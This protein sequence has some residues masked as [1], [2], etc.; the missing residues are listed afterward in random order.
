MQATR[1]FFGLTILVGSLI[2]VLLVAM[3]LAF[4]S[5]AGSRPPSPPQPIGA[6]TRPAADTLHFSLVPERDIFAQRERYRILARYLA[7]QICRP[8]EMV[9][10]ANYQGVLT[11]FAN[12]ETDGAFVGSLVAVL[13]HEMY[14]AEVVA[15]PE[16]P[17]GISTYRGVIFVHQDSP[18]QT[19]AQLGGHSLGMVRATTAGHLF[20]I[21]VL[22]DQG[23]LDGPH[24]AQMRW[25][26][27]HDDVIREVLCGHLDAG[28]VKDLRLEAWLADHPRD[29]VRR[30]ATSEAV[31]ENA[32]I[33]RAG[34]DPALRR[35]LQAALLRMDQT[36]QGRAVLAQLG[37]A[38]F[39][40]CD[41]S[42]YRAVYAIARRLG[43]L[44][45]RLGLNAPQPPAGVPPDV[46]TQPLR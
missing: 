45:Q 24:A 46:A 31:P 8:I 32:L 39:I 34:M 9:T 11:G 29:Q 37:A 20:P 17:N 30:L 44:W 35:H 18:I 16:L 3:P 26:G 2:V 10:P 23:L 4:R 13:A 19:V 36:P 15:K 12:G 6:T 40:P 27:T 28:A 33:V 5:G 25:L 22:N 7:A 38:R 14:G 41:I 21:D 42:Q 43:P 1:M